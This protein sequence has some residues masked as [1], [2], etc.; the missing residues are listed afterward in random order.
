[1]ECPRSPRARAGAAGRA[2]SGSSC[3]TPTR[4][5]DLRR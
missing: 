2:T 1:M 3:A 5:S 4:R